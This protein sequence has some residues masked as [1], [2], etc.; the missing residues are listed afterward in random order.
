MCTNLILESGFSSINFLSL[1]AS[2]PLEQGRNSMER[3]WG[4]KNSQD[5][6]KQDHSLSSL[7]LVLERPNPTSIHINE[8]SYLTLMSY[9]YLITLLISFKALLGIS[10]YVFVEF[11]TQFLC[12]SLT[13]QQ[14]LRGRRPSPSCLP[15]PLYDP[16]SCLAH[17]RCSVY[18]C[19]MS[20]YIKTKD[21]CPYSWE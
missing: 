20:G 9:F 3:R 2:F 16:A 17:S 12:V 7:G 14:A 10:N 8:V 13:R 15:Q 21:I 18:I 6:N 5:K 11:P 19:W 4:P 1:L